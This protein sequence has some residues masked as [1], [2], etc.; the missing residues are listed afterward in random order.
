MINKIRAI[1]MAHQV[2]G[3]NFYVTPDGI[4]RDYN[5]LGG[6]YE[7]KI[8]NNRKAV[9]IEDS[10]GKIIEEIALSLDMQNATDVEAGGTNKPKG[11]KKP[12]NS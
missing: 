3:Q 4:K 7:F 11:N 5:L 1:Q 12:A 10:K 2:Q 9:I 6:K 8:Y